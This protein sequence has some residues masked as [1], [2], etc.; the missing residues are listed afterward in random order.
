MR[1]LLAL[2]ALGAVTT[3]CFGR[4]S[5]AMNQ[6]IEPRPILPGAV[7]QQEIAIEGDGLLG[8]A[9]R[10]AMTQAQASANATAGWQLRDNS[11][12]ATSRFRIFRSVAL[13]ANGTQQQNAVSGDPGKVQVSS[14]DWIVLRR[15][16]VQVDVSAPD[17]T[18]APSST[19][20]Q[21]QQLA[22][23]ALA[24]ITYDHY[25]R[26]PGVVTSTNGTRSDDGR[27]V[28]HVS[29]TSPEPQQSLVAESV[30][31]DLPRLALFAFVL[32]ALLTWRVVALLRRGPSP[33]QPAPPA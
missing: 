17:N 25:L 12:G 8:A 28:W 27:I 20:P 31:P 23:L 2:I 18:V 15:Y 26:M 19:D 10:Q 5:I 29:F 30:Y 13:D 22:Q 21:S 1:R 3:S 32:L 16:R 6:Q 33:H 11:D 24:G 7:L 9:A 14:T 4:L